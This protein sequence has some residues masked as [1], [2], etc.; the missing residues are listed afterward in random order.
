MSGR[1]SY[2]GDLGFEIWCKPEYQCY[3]FDELMAAGVADNIRLFG[4]RALNSLRLEKSYGSWA[5]EYRPIYSPEE[6]G[7]NWFVDI[8]KDADFI[9]K[10]STVNSKDHNSAKV[11]L[12]TFI[13][14]ADNADPI[15]DEPIYLNGKAVGWVTSGGYAHSSGVSVAIGYIP[16]GH[17]NEHDGWEIEIIGKRRK[18]TMQQ[19]PL[20]DPQGSRMRG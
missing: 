11:R 5:R 3:I 16:A 8:E 6:C 14:D 13:V 20:F 18:A 10:K 15:G 17:S 1:V 19:K 9:G 4:T 7:L 2:T 12:R